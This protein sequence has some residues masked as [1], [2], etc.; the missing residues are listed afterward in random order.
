MFDK[1]VK[2]WN[3]QRSVAYTMTGE[4]VE[5]IDHG[6]IKSFAAG[7]AKGVASGAIITATGVA[8]GVLARVAI[9]KLG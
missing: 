8:I 5:I 9:N 6:H 3:G 7:A 2:D 1:I 4:K